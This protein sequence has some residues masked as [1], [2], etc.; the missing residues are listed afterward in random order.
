MIPYRASKLTQL[1]QE[2]LS[3]NSNTCMLAAVSPSSLDYNETI[4]TLQYVT[5]T[6]I[7]TLTVSRLAFEARL[8][9][10]YTDAA[11]RPYQE[12]T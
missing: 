8:Q 9:Q 2:G 10:D 11:V 12:I 7:V 6:L 5:V 3:G 4:Q 1:L